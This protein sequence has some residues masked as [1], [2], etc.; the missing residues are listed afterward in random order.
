MDA[1]NRAEYYTSD[2]EQIRLE[3]EDSMDM[4]WLIGSMISGIVIGRENQEDPAE[5]I[6][7]L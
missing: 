4:M 3:A 7:I 6:Q 1:T 2:G 5:A